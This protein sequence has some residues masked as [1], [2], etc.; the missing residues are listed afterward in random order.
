M[1]KVTSISI[2]VI[3]CAILAASIAM[4]A[5]A[6]DI[7]LVFILLFNAMLG[8]AVYFDARKNYINPALVWAFVS[9]FASGL[10]LVV[11]LFVRCLPRHSINA[12]D[13]DI[14]FQANTDK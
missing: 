13:C 5:F 2:S 7:I 8:V 1:T 12:Y 4:Y 3:I 10:G 14:S 9:L 11:Y 6:F